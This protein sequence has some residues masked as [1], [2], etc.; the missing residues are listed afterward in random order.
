M[1]GDLIPSLLA[2]WDGVS[3][4]MP[5]LEAALARAP[6]AN[7]L[8]D[9][10]DLQRAAQHDLAALPFLHAAP[11]GFRPGG[12]AE[13]AA[14]LGWIIATL[15]GWDQNCDP[16]GRRLTAALIAGHI[17]NSRLD[18][19]AHLRTQVPNWAQVARGCAGL[20][21]MRTGSA[22]LP[23]S[24]PLWQQELL[25]SFAE[26]EQEKNWSALSDMAA[27]FP[28]VHFDPA[29]EEATRTLWEVDR[30]LL[31][32]VTDRTNGWFRAVQILG[33]L[34]FPDAMALAAQSSSGHIHLAA[35]EGAR[36]EAGANLPKEAAEALEN[37]LVKLAGGTEAWPAWLATFNTYPGGYPGFQVPLG[38]ALARSTEAAALAY[39]DSISLTT[40]GI[41][42]SAVAL[43]MSAFRAAASDHLRRRLWQFAHDRWRRWNFDPGEGRE[44]ANIARSEL[45]FGV[46]G[47][48]IVSMSP[49][50]LAAEIDA[51]P[52]RL[53]ALENMWHSSATA[54]RGATN[55]LLSAHQL[56]AHASHCTQNPGADWLPSDVTYIPETLKSPYA[57]ARHPLPS[58]LDD[59]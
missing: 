40:S 11:V 22:S 29:A 39:V 17:W 32:E 38:R 5:A 44:L 15:R 7:L 1:T 50:G 18:L 4:N 51:F 42:R 48:F 34:S 6:N 58:P 55:R 2:A 54:L 53:R 28:P 59:S 12:Q 27:S 35:L 43:C 33:S 14:Q 37:L 9:L 49:A 25:V 57:R 10:D 36:R 45:D 26:A 19:W 24:A 3:A 41:G 52:D 46:V 47:W 13:L 8:T 56:F 21:V 20:I 30:P 23:E 16:D 31:I